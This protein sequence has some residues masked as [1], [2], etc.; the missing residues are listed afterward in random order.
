VRVRASILVI[1]SAGCYAPQIASGL[2][3]E[4]S[5]PGNEVCI[6]GVCRQPGHV[7][8]DATFD[9]DLSADAPALD[10]APSDLDGDGVLD[11][12]DNCPA[13]PNADQHDEDGDGLGDVCDPCPHLAGDDADADGDGVGD[14]CDPQ[15]AIAKQQIAFFDPFTTARSEWLSTLDLVGGQ[16][17]VGGSQFVRLGVPTGELR[18]VTGGTL[19][20]RTAT[21]HQLSVSFGFNGGGSGTSNYYYGEFYDT[22][23][24]NGAVKIMRAASSTFTALA[25]T[26]YAGTMPSGAWSMRI[27][28]SAAGQ[29]VDLTGVIGGAAFTA[30]TGSTGNPEHVAGTNIGFNI[31]N[32]D[33]AFDYVVVIRTLP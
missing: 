19:A 18:I 27:D 23:A 1:A 17:R 6:A 2:A 20:P 13:H 11:G 25:S 31:Q 33:I 30:L 29:R 5:C 10:A 4:T 24:S 16:W 9:G 12:D 28:E 15:P 14:A 21:P 22:S 3:C 7:T 8:A 26:P 32:L